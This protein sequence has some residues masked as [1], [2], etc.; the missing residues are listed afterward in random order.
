M[1]LMNVQK[2]LSARPG[3][4]YWLCIGRLCDGSGLIRT[5][6]ITASCVTELEVQ[7]DAILNRYAAALCMDERITSVYQ[8]V[9]QLRSAISWY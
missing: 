7:L 3:M 2:D 5:L 6:W 9:F 1:F 4:Q 8:E